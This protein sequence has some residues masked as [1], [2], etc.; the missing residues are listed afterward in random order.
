MIEKWFYGRFRISMLIPPF[1]LEAAC[2]EYQTVG[3]GE[4][5][6]RDRNTLKG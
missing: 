2:Q 6:G 4:V 5:D 1:K 3:F